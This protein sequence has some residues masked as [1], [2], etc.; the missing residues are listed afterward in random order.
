MAAKPML[1]SFRD[2][3]R[4]T[5]TDESPVRLQKNR[6]A[7]HQQVLAV[8]VHV[9]PGDRAAPANADFIRAVCALAASAPV[10]K[11]IV[12]TVMMINARGLDPAMVRQRVHRR[13]RGDALPGFGVQ[14]D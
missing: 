14:L 2:Y 13:V 8:L 10:H 11:K 6:P 4:V 5:R 3:A 9:W 1:V 7:V 12:I